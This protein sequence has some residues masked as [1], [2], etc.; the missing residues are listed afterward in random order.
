MFRLWPGRAPEAAAIAA[1]A[2]ASPLLAQTR[3]VVRSGITVA[4]TAAKPK[5]GAAAE[6]DDA[7]QLQLEVFVNDRPSNLVVPFTLHAD[8]T[9]GTAAVE[10]TSLGVKV[11]AVLSKEDVEVSLAALPGVTYQYDEAAQ[12][13]RFTLA[14]SAQRPTQ[15]NAQDVAPSTPDPVRP[16]FGAVANYTLFASA[17]EGPG[18]PMFQGVSGA[19]ETRVFGRFGL[20]ENSFVARSYGTQKLTRLDSTYTYEDP[21]RLVIYAAGDVISGGF[22]WTRPIRMAGLQIRRSFGLRP[23]LITTA[24]PTLSGTAAAPSTL[25]LFVNK[26]RTLSSDV[27]QGPYEI[28]HPPIIYGSGQARIVLRDVLGRETVS[29]TAFY[30]SPELLTRGLSDFSAEVGFA[31]RNYATLSNDYDGRPT[32]T[33]SYRQGLSK[34]LTAVAHAEGAGGGLITLGGGATFTLANLALGSVAVSGSR[35]PGHSGALVDVSLESRM[36]RLSVLLRTQRTFGDYEDLASWTAATTPNLPNERRLYGQPRELDQVS[37]SMPL[38]SGASVGGSYV[39]LRRADDARSRLVNLSFTQ[40][41]GRLA[42]FA[43]A[44]RDFEVHASTSIFAGISLPLGHGVTASAGA[45]QARG[46]TSG[47]VEASRQGAQDPGNWGWS[48]R[49]S[50]GQQQEAQAIV[51][52]S[53]SFARFEATG[54]YSDGQGSVTGLM[55][56]AVSLVGGEVHVTPRIDNSFALVEVG[57]PDVAVMRENHK[58]GVT[59]RQGKLLVP[60]L[61]P[62]VTNR[63]SIDPAGLPIDV[64]VDATE[65]TTSPF[66]RVPSLVD[67]K[68][69]QGRGTALVTLVDPQSKPIE[70]GSTVKIEGKDQDFIVGYDGEA[71]LEDLDSETVLLV[72]TPDRATCRAR[73]RFAGKPGEQTRIGPTVCEP[74]P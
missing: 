25:D 39:R 34:G 6:A 3:D 58:V 23:D 55:E 44:S 11:P 66:S 64:R 2:I 41:L 8:G 13:I 56:G 24:L 4:P 28:A 36:A 52:Y 37:L 57:A 29:T 68:V 67:L 46:E 15:V 30:A 19:F 17:D 18:G 9:I 5:D 1:L 73:F 48:V 35:T 31:R 49:A 63:I 69:E 22:S 74:Q 14:P 27:P 26:V 10:L 62:F 65:T 54:L 59:D 70:L 47:Y 33:G 7:Q 40:D 42:L 20:L 32:F 12:T 51:R 38:W 53:A 45:T 50:E 61:A 43:S 21:D 72:T 16:P 71:Y 60:D